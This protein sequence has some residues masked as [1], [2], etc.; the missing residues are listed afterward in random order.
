MRAK[1]NLETYQLEVGND[2]I[3]LWRTTV[4]VTRSD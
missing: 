1:I 2:R 3:P 4:G